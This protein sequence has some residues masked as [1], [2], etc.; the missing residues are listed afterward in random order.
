MPISTLSGSAISN[1]YQRVVQTDGLYLGDGTGSLINNLSLPGNLY[2]GGTLYA[3]NS[4]VVTESFYSGSNQFGNDQNDIQLLYGT[5]RI[6][7]GSLTVTGSVL[8]N[9]NNPINFGN[10]I[11][12]QRAGTNILYASSLET[13]VNTIGTSPIRFQIGS[14]E[15]ARITGS[16][17]GIGTTSPTEKLQV[18]GNIRVQSSLTDATSKDF[19]LIQ[20][21]YTNAQASLSII[22]TVSNATQNIIWIGGGNASYNTAT[23]IRFLT[24]VTNTTLTGTERMRIASDGNVGI[25]TTS[26]TSRLQVRGSGTTS[27]TTAFRVENANTS[28]SLLVTDDGNVSITGSLNVS[29]S[30]ISTSPITGQS[31]LGTGLIVNNNNGSTSISDFEVKTQLYDA[32]YV[33]SS[34]NSLLLMSNANGKV[35]FFGATPNTQS[36]GWN[37]TNA[38][39]TKSFD[40]DTITLAQLADVVGTLI[41]EFKAKGLLG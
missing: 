1:T 21:H 19:S 11:N 33:S 16:F 23:D 18:I 15:V 25:G 31:I 8:I 37:T 36:L 7:T 17:F 32:I 5:V 41:A 10:Q 22:N 27:T 26:P 6:P 40:A 2:V 38:Q 39:V 28:A 3:N 12:I 14:S 9:E 20:G 29:G 34:L 13:I 4:V 30:I 35:G 24:A